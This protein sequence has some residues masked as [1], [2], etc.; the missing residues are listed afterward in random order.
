MS[1]TETATRQT[2]QDKRP[3]PSPL[4]AVWRLIG[5]QPGWFALATVSWLLFQAW[6]LLPGVLA[7]AFFD[8]M[9]GDTRAGLTLPTLLALI[10]SAGLARMVIIV[11]GTVA[12]TRWRVVSRMLL[13]RN[14]LARVLRL[15]GARAVPQGVG[16]SI[17]TLRDD[18]EAVSMMGDWVY[19]L[20]AA[21]A[22]IGGGTAILLFVDVKVTLLVVPPVV[23]VV[24]IAQ[25]ARGRFEK[26]R[27]RTRSTT[28]DVT[29]AITDIVSGARAVQAAGAED[30]VVARLRQLGE[31]RRIA[32]LRDDFYAAWLDA[33][34]ASTAS[35]GAGLTLLVAAESMRSGQFTLGDF[36]LF[37]T[38]LLQVTF[39]TRFIGYLARTKRQALVSIRR[40]YDLMQGAT[41]ADL[42]AS[43]NLH[44]G[45]AGSPPATPVAVER[46]ELSSL[47]V[48][49]LT[50]TFPGSAA[51]IRDVDFTVPRGSLTV[52]TGRVGTGK[53]TLL[54]ALIGL[55]PPTTGTV[56]W[57]G[58]AIESAADFMV[59]P[60]VAYMPQR[61]ALLSGTLRDNIL[62]GLPLDDENVNSA[63]RDAVLTRD[64]A[65]IRDG[66][67]TEIGV[68]GVRLSGGQLQR[69]AAARMFVRSAELLVI[70]DMSSA[71]DME[72][73]LELWQRLRSRN[74]TCIAVSHRRVALESATQII[75][76][77]E[78]RVTGTGTL[79]EL[80]RDS[81]EMQRL[82]AAEADRNVTGE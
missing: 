82:Y 19:D 39:F 9:T 31:Q 41:Q 59:P 44:L 40:V 14:I 1:D 43:R 32:V 6:P 67:D 47:Q 20:T 81:P 17:S 51:G 62:L 53:T 2:D 38:Y 54:R 58:N 10:T 56:T 18:T 45:E 64:M 79:A 48:S 78:G 63:I 30:T 76:L 69:T 37:S 60:N 74:T 12:G 57:N 26:F 65:T 22:F 49:G 15:P 68:A 75:L 35:L 34:F 50:V 5:H 7:K 70:D 23:A 24:V 61:P 3:Q 25:A 55:L 27:E 72:T 11:S 21:A 16:R 80:L 13:Q 42:V 36:V 46:E 66:L 8:L 77:E 28:A 4:R 29:G 71:L 73:E 33:V 52:I